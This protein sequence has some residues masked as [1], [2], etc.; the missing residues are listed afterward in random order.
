MNKNKIIIHLALLSIVIVGAILYFYVFNDYQEILTNNWISL[1]FMV[2]VI[3]ILI[4]L[5]F[6]VLLKYFQEKIPNVFKKENSLP[7]TPMQWKIYN[8]VMMFFVGMYVLFFL[9]WGFAILILGGMW[10]WAYYFGS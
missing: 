4:E 2:I 10:L 5:F 7:S 8:F 1:I 3:H 9:V 6:K